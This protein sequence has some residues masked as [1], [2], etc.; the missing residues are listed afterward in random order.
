MAKALLPFYALYVGDGS[1]STFVLDVSKDPFYFANDIASFN[2]ADAEPGITALSPQFDHKLAPSAVVNLQA[3]N[4][5]NNSDF[6]A[7]LT[8]IDQ[9]QITFSCSSTPGNG[10][11]FAAQG[12]I[13]Y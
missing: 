12:F 10:V 11:L 3:K 13:E 4:A 6:G 8:S 5:L 9:Y 7:S 2:A 1:T